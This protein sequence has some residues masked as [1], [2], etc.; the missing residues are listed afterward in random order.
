ML[1]WMFYRALNPILEFTRHCNAWIEKKNCMSQFFWKGSQK[2]QLSH[3]SNW[4]KVFK[5]GATKICGRQLLSPYHLK[6]FKGCLPQV[7]L[8]P[9]L[10]ALSHIKQLFAYLIWR[11]YRRQR[12]HPRKAMKLWR[13]PLEIL[14]LSVNYTFHFCFRFSW[15]VFHIISNRQAY[16]SFYVLIIKGFG[17]K[18]I[19]DNY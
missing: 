13:K 16:Y 11:N 5:N 3:W 4:G 19:R 10:N 2:I 17:I 9:F 1:S 12:D 8:G 14:I 15:A 18:A 7:L 6:F